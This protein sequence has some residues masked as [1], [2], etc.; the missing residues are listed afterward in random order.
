MADN[1]T[2]PWDEVVAALHAVLTTLVARGQYPAGHPAVER[3]DATAS[4]GMTRLLTGMAELVVALVENEYVV[5]ER[6]M[7][8]LRDRIPGF[9]EAM[10]RHDIECL[11]FVR[12]VTRA[13]FSVLASALVEPRAEDPARARERLQASLPH[14]LLRFVELKRDDAQDDQVTAPSL[15]PGVRAMLDSIARELEKGARIDEDAVRATARGVLE[16]CV[17]RTVPLQLR[18]YDPTDDLPAHVVNT[19]V[20]TC[21]MLLETGI[22][23]DVCV[24][25]AAAALLHDIGTLLLPEAIRGMPEPLLDEQ[26]RKAYR[27]HPILG[28]R[29]LLLSGAPGMW[30]EAALQHHRGID[31]QGYPALDSDRPPH[32]IA[33]IVALANFVERRRTILSGMQDEPEQVITRCTALLGHYFDA[34]CI[35]LF[36]RALGVFPPGTTVQ[37]STGE[38]AVV[39]RVHAGEPMRPRV[40]V[41]SGPNAGKKLDLREFDALE[42]RYLR[43]IV[44]AIAPPLAVRA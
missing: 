28:A 15:V 2:I 16:G 11:V 5:A 43:S 22:P 42:G 6:P 9:A 36:M 7:P 37:L 20:M 35:A 44:Q 39:T 14:I 4:N 1:R 25:G 32:E 17:S 41:L 27:Y 31:L 26:G 29:A 18:A 12:G 13:E 19:A 8:E 23:D 38:S 30:V 24:E 3:A 10:L 21:A 40:R 34:R 33:R